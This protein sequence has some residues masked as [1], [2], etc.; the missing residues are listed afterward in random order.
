M[1]DISP[2]AVNG[3]VNG[4]ANAID[5]GNDNASVTDD[6]NVVSERMFYVAYRRYITAFALRP[7]RSGGRRRLLPAT[8][9]N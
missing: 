7:E 3:G 5:N 2:V 9:R 6:D 1:L 8:T 4:D